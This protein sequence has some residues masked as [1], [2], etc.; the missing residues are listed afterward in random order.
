MKP[1]IHTE[2]ILKDGLV[3]AS[4][5][6]EDLFDYFNTLHYMLSETEFDH[7]SQFAKNW[8]DEHLADWDTFENSVKT[9]AW[10]INSG[11]HVGDYYQALLLRRDQL[12]A[13]RDVFREYTRFL[14]DIFGDDR[15]NVMKALQNFNFDEGVYLRAKEYHEVRDSL[16]QKYDKLL[17]GELEDIE[18]EIA[19]VD[20]G[21][22]IADAPAKKKRA[23]RKTAAKKEK[24]VEP[25]E[26][27]TTRR[28]FRKSI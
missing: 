21:L 8:I 24:E 15:D 22:E 1:I 28:Y 16:M 3:D 12:L 19:R 10:E 6:R 7:I 9:K 2:Y 11:D 13:A 27:K 4:A 20:G 14:R 18:K 23:P 26:K 25:K 5:L 17:E